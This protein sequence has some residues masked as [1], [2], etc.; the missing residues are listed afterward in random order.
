MENI[1]FAII[2]CVSAGKSTFF[3]AICSYTYSDMKRKKTTMLPQIYQTTDDKKLIDD[4]K[5]IYKKNKDSNDNI[6]SKRENNTFNIETDFKVINHFIGK[7][8]DFINIKDNYSILDMPGLN[9]GGDTLYYDYIKNTSTNIDIYILVI[10]VNSAL[11]T[12][13]EI[14]II[15]LVVEQ[16]T[17]NNNGYIHI[18]I[19]KCDDIQYDKS[20]NI[21]LSDGELD[22]MYKRAVTIIKK[23]CS[24]I[25]DKVSWS[26]ICSS[27]LYIYRG[28][29]NNIDN[30]DEK[31][32]DDIIAQEV[33]KSELRKMKSVDIKRKFIIGKLQENKIE[34]NSWMKETGY[35]YFQE[36]INN[37]IKKNYDNIIFY[38]INKDIESIIKSI[39]SKLLITIDELNDKLALINHRINK[40]KTKI[41]KCIITNLEYINTYINTQLISGIN[42]YSGSTIDICIEYLS[43]IRKYINTL[44]SVFPDNNKIIEAEKAITDKKFELYIKQFLIKFDHDTYYI[45]V[46]NKKLSDE[47]LNR[48][49]KTTL[50]ED[51]S[52][53]KFIINNLRK[54]DK[55]LINLIIATYIELIKSKSNNLTFEQFKENTLI[56][57]THTKDINI[58][59]K[60]TRDYIRSLIWGSV[61]H[62]YILN[63]S[64]IN[65]YSDDIKL[66]Y[67][68]YYE[69]N[70]YI[71]YRDHPNC[72][73]IDIDKIEYMT[74]MNIMNNLFLE[75]LNKPVLIQTYK[76]N[77]EYH[78][79]KVN[80]EYHSTDENTDDEVKSIIK[81]GDG[82]DS[83]MSDDYDINDGS[84]TVYNK[85][86]KNATKKTKKIMKNADKL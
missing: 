53:F 59:Y 82:G 46:D 84:D 23:E 19:N 17:L 81:F 62:W 72:D 40:L 50:Q 30:I 42:T 15:R 13:D 78:S 5:T 18:L 1:N 75:Y 14:N 66:L 54:E 36:S 80:D 68:N 61:W 52:L 77:D 60:S 38:H 76:V 57:L 22:E 43:K 27:K 26:P 41:P 3:N 73:E 4:I 58:I 28:I 83:D 10:D 65:T 6:L 2:G 39:D 64:Q 70:S 29:K 71:Y 56:I 9:C 67:M 33:G 24:S 55:H 16:I 63:A 7:I 25:I 20:N 79:T 44:M 21:H 8:P 11:N 34:Y 35:S 86:I 37:T 49:L 69:F 48:S 31:Q 47:I 32:L 85:A 74:K 45:L 12:T 51:F